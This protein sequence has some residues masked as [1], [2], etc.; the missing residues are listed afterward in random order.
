MSIMAS[1]IPV[2]WELTILFLKVSV[3]TGILLL[4]FA[5]YSAYRIRQHQL[6]EIKVIENGRE[7]QEDNGDQEWFDCANKV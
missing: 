5:S 6:G 1:L 4:D 2:T 3:K 7:K